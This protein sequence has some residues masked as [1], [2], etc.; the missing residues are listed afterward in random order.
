M[1]LLVNG[2]EQEMSVSGIYQDVTNGGRTAKA[3]LPYNPESVLWYAVSLDL[4]STDRID[5]KVHEYSQAFYPA[6]VTD[7]EGYLTQTLG[8]TIDQFGK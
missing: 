1:V 4:K 5:E 8:N 6:R 7:L 3:L 2:Q